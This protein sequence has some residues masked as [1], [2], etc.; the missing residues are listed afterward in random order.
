VSETSFSV[1]SYEFP[2]VSIGVPTYGRPDGLRRLLGQLVSQTYQNIEIIVSDNCHPKLEGFEVA[3]NLSALDSRVVVYRQ[4]QN[5]GAV[6]NHDFV[7]RVSH[8]DYFMWIGDDDE[9]APNY[10]EECMK[11]IL[12]SENISLVGGVGRRFLNGEFWR[13]YETFDT[14]S[15]CTYDRLRLLSE[16]AF[17]KYW[18][19]E[20]YL[21]GVFRKRRAPENVSPYLEN[22]L[23]HIFVLAESGQIAHNP[24]ALMVKHTTQDEINNHTALVGYKKINSLSFLRGKNWDNLQNCVPI[25]LQMMKVVLFS[26]KLTVGAKLSLAFSITCRFIK[27]PVAKEIWLYAPRFEKARHFFR[28]IHGGVKRRIFRAN[29]TNG[30]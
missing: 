6:L 11:T 23:R 18:S 4:P 30:G 9:I 16:F 10:V 22:V 27:Y 7:K 3:K 2:L 19:F 17:A 20:H 29:L 14:Q 5:V 13:D 8:G 15:L 28:R 24:N 25:Y 1:S 12:K 26:G 21:Y